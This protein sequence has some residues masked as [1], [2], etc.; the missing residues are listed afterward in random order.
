MSSETPPQLANTICST[1]PLHTQ[2]SVRPAGATDHL[3]RA[4]SIELDHPGGLSVIRF[5]IRPASRYSLWQQELI[6]L[7]QMLGCL[8][9]GWIGGFVGRPSG[10]PCWQSLVSLREGD[11][12]ECL[13]PCSA[14]LFFFLWSPQ[15]LVFALPLKSVCAMKDEQ[16]M[17][18]A[19]FISVS[20]SS[21]LVSLSSQKV[22]LREWRHLDTETSSLGKIGEM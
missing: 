18:T 11:L 3:L 5:D 17:R 6:E 12:T 10:A 22:G 7:I 21:N 16:V 4:T 20:E 19:R 1:C 14:S 9:R 2:G 15:P 8:W 13:G